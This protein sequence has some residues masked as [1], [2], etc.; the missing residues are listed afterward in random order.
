M[1]SCG[2]GSAV[3][4][5]G[6]G[7]WSKQG[8]MLSVVSFLI[9]AVPASAFALQYSP[10]SLGF[11]AAPGGPN[12]PAQ[13][14]TIWTR[15]SKEK[16]WS[17]ASTV[18]WLS[19]SPVSGSI[20]VERDSI[21]VAVNASGLAA[22]SYASSLMITVK[23]VNGTIRKTAIPVILT[24]EAAT[25]SPVIAVSP[26]SL[27]LSGIV[28]GPNP[29]TKSF[30]VS[31]SGGGTL[32]WTATDNAAWLTLSPASGTNTGTVNAS[33][34]VRGLAAGTYNAMITVSG[35]G[36]PS[37]SLAVSLT[38]FSASVGSTIGFSPTSLAFDGTAGGTNPAGKTVTITNTGG[39]TLTWTI[40]DDAPWL[41]VTPTSGTTTTEA[42][43]LTA[44]VNIGGLAAGTYNGAITIAATGATNSPR[45][46]PVSLTLSAS[47][48]GSATLTWSANTESDLAGYKIYRA[49]A[50][51]AYGAPVAMIEK[52]TSAYVVT[53]LQR[54]TTY[55]FVVTAY[56]TAGN[57]SAFS[58]EVSK[59][60][61]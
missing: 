26:T 11:V 19:A 49:T 2:G 5:I 46:I 25:G 22:G 12:P 53:G 45:T 34:D 51:G 1:A 56:D 38:V 7:S 58:N 59:S 60:V 20:S 23:N 14:L 24:V 29:V 13:T 31:N 10:T 21:Q 6:R 37:K 39:G 47:T 27:T 36:V 52:S 35:P 30:T 3:Y 48:A 9:V 44:T 28:G 55:F 42:D 33:A 32:S 18:A 57:E 15:G 17:A 8:L 50:S 4:S 41:S 16:S 61:Y 40:S 54:G 43:T